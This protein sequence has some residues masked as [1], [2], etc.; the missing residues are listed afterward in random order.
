M[1]SIKTNSQYFYFKNMVLK[2]KMW[3]K[4]LIILIRNIQPAQPSTL[5]L[6]DGLHNVS[7]DFTWRTWIKQ[8]SWLWRSPG[9]FLLSLVSPSALSDMSWLMCFSFSFTKWALCLAGQ[10]FFQVIESEFIFGMA[11]VPLHIKMCKE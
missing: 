3:L 7:H 11:I 1:T 4:A 5:T 9:F 2:F 6:P 8:Q 10:L